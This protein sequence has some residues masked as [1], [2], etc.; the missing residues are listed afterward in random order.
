M[1]ALIRMSEGHPGCVQALVEIVKHAPDPIGI[2]L[3]LDDMNMRGD[4]IWCGYHDVCDENVEAFIRQ[5][6]ERD[7]RLLTAVNVLAF[8]DDET[9]VPAGASDL[10][11]PG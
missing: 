1:D 2:L 3:D 10:H 7:S 11:R 9:V 4:Q 8:S 5:G 6:L